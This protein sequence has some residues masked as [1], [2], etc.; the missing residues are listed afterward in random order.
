MATKAD[1]TEQEWTQLERG[2]M[3]TTLLVS[4]SDAGFFE[5]F[6]EAGAAGR[7]LAEARKGNE[8]ELIRELAESRP[9]M[10]YGL[11]MSPQELETQTL[12]AL[13]A[14]ASALKAKAPDELPAYRQ[15]VLDVAQSVAAAAEGVAAG[16]T[17]AMEKIRSALDSA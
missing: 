15:F 1:F 4:I 13:R 12:E 10:G 3:G 17:G 16:E 14:A 2:V 7:H 11:G 9:G 6:K 8:S 5:T